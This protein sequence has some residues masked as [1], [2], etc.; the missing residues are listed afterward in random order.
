MCFVVDY[1]HFLTTNICFFFLGGGGGGGK[2]GAS[3][4]KQDALL[5]FSRDA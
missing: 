1:M 5:A 2:T 3:E 4:R